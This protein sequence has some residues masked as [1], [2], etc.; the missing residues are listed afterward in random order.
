MKNRLV[1]NVTGERPQVWVVAKCMSV[2]HQQ[3]YIRRLTFS[4]F[5]LHYTQLSHTKLS[6]SV[7][8]GRYMKLFLA[9]VGFC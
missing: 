4:S 1:S 6:F 8:Y 9:S 2:I 3:N 5:Y 7:T